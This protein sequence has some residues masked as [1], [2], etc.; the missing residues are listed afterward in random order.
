RPDHKRNG[1]RPRL[2]LEQ[3]LGFDGRLRRQ[4]PSEHPERRQGE[5]RLGFVAL[6]PGSTGA[7]TVDGAGSAWTTAG[8]FFLGYD[9]NGTL[10]VRNSGTL[11]NV[12][13]YIGLSSTSTSTA[14]VDGAGSTW[15]NGG[16]L[17]VGSFGAR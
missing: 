15:T 3:Q 7:V 1:R 2:N 17:Y 13:G 12:T 11:S 5:Q 9:G 6:D 10:T 8:D 16:N 4:R 14:T